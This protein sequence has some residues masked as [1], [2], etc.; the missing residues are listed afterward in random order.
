[1]DTWPRTSITSWQ[2]MAL[3]S[4]KLSGVDVPEA[5]MEAARLFLQRAWDRDLGD[6]RYS[7]DPSRL[8]SSWPT[9]PASTPAA[10]FALSILGEDLDER[11]YRT[12]RAAVI[13]NA[14]R[15]YRWRGDDAFVRRGEGNLYHWYYGSLAMFRAGGDDWR[16]WNA[17]L[18]EALLPAQN[19]DGS[20]P[21]RG[22]H[23]DDYAGDDRR[24]LS[25]TTAMC[26]LCLEVYYRYLT[27]VVEG[28]R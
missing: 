13:E 23:A 21:L 5:S 28:S 11:R 25:Y 10:L 14:P 18:Q 9:L 6:Y 26:V 27:P 4:A 15:G 2:V 7:H 3:E 8:R 24:D 16:R 12:A 19:D 20:W 17:A 22:G 1:V